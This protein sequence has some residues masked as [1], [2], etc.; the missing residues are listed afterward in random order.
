VEHP[1]NLILIGSGGHARVVA[2]AARSAGFILQGFIDIDY[3]GQNEHILGSP[4]LGGIELLHDLDHLKYSIMVA[5]GDNSKRADHYIH[6]Q[7]KGFATP[8]VIHPTAVV[9]NDCVIE[10]G[11]FINTSA[12]INAEAKIGENAIINTSAI[13]EHEVVVGKHSH[14]GPGVKI[15][16]RTRIGKRTFIGIGTSVID[17]VNIGTNVIIGAGSVIIDN[18][19]NND[20]VVGVP[21]RGIK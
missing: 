13:I 14:I 1:N 9:S 18:V 17:N 21:G 2:D 8:T 16:G 10:N 20:T 12:I 19:K 3:H 11:V 5:I 7:T 15:G 6:A 4:V